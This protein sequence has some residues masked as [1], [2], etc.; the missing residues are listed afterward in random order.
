M[1][2]RPTL[3]AVF[4]AVAERVAIIDLA[5][6]YDWEIAVCPALAAAEKEL[7]SRQPALILYDRDTPGPDWRDAFELLSRRS[8]ESS[9]IL[10]S[11][12]ADEYLWQE[13]V[14]LGGYD[15]LAK[16]ISAE[17]AANCINL[18]WA[19]FRSGFRF[20]PAARRSRRPTR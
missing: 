15:V 11:S 2:A 19:F 5:A 10:V 9:I 13:V 18:A 7:V 14:Q 1:I 12:V 17:A 4:P 3:L 16:P 20:A 6:H 8:G